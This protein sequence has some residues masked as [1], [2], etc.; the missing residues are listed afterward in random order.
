MRR[1]EAVAKKLKAQ[2]PKDEPTLAD[3]SA[4]LLRDLGGEDHSECGH[5]G[6]HCEFSEA[7]VLLHTMSEPQAVLTASE[8]NDVEGT[9]MAVKELLEKLDT[10]MRG[11]G[12][13]VVDPRSPLDRV[14]QGIFRALML[15]KVGRVRLGVTK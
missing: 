4:A 11:H 14:Y 6:G 9:L 13:Q 12:S 15:M 7:F 5:E 3:V 10:T 1:R 2:L 8:M